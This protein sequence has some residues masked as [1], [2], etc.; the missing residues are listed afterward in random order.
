MVEEVI[1]ML[2]PR[3]GG[4]Y[5]DLTLGLGGH[6]RRILKA[7]G[8]NGFLV[9][10][11]RDGAAL[12][13][14]RQELA[15]FKDRLRIFQGCYS[16]LPR[17]LNQMGWDS[18]DGMLV[19]LGVSSLQLDDAERGFGFQSPGPI[20]MRMNPESGM[21]LEKLLSQVDVS[22]LA[23]VLR[24]YGEVDKPKL[25]ANRILKA[26]REGNLTNTLDLAKIGSEPGGR[27]K[28]HPATRVFLA[29]RIWVNQELEELD[30]MLARLPE[31]LSEGG[32]LVVLS[33]HSLEDR[34]VKARFRELSSGCVC[35]TKLP[36]C[37]CGYRPVLKCLHGKPIRPT[38][39]ENRSNPRSRSAVLRAAERI[40]PVKRGMQ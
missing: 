29:L 22:S 13:Q 25:L 38:Q 31:P 20:D 32:R 28:I 9:G 4:R 2:N 30:E 10:I 39:A 34:K 21:P 19:D 24:R 16:Q 33:F 23:G 15:P 7:C 18:V 36:V 1:T 5:V 14:A 3:P 8:P 12:E 37:R 17:F 6:A 40:A 27:R 11:E 35:P 26:H